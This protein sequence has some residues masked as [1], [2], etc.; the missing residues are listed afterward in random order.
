MSN[1]KKFDWTNGATQFAVSET[2]KSRRAWSLV[3]CGDW[4][5]TDTQQRALEANPEKFY[6]D[7]L[8]ILRDTDLIAFNLECV[9]SDRELAAIRKDG[10]ILRVPLRALRSLQIAPFRLACMANNHIFDLGR[11]GLMDTLAALSAYHIRAVGAGE[12]AVSAESP[13]IFE[14]D[15]MRIAVLNVAEGEEAGAQGGQPG[16]AILDVTRLPAQIAS[17][18]TQADVVIVIVHAGREFLPVPAPHIRHTF[19]ALAQAGADLIVGHHP[20]VPQGIEF[21]N[22]TPIIYSLGNFAFYLDTPVDWQHIGYFVRAQFVGAQLCALETWFYRIEPDG[23]RLLQDAE[24]AQIRNAISELTE[25]LVDDDKLTEIWNAYVDEWLMRQGREEIA[26]SVALFTGNT[27][28]GQAMLKS[29]V[30]RFKTKRLIR[31]GM[32]RAIHWLDKRIQAERRKANWFDSSEVQRG[33]TI[34]RNRFDTPSHREL[35]LTA[36]Q[37]VMTNQVGRSADWAKNKIMRWQSL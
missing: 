8:P 14:I 5:P 31:S 1:P 4:S 22:G 12:D 7:L 29:A 16:A 34:L 11:D 32:W 24:L 36:L 13:A 3:I 37:R 30:R 2:P 10:D 17:L 27:V 28:M 23:M 9:V 15:E 19:R 33:A 26:E 6:A 20:H 25:L 18:R 21:Y 35:Y